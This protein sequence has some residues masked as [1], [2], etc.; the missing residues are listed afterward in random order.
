MLSGGKQR[1]YGYRKKRIQAT[2]NM[3]S[4]Q[5]CIILLL[6]DEGKIFYKNMEQRLTGSS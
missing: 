4:E 2:M 1:V 6:R 3:N 5:C